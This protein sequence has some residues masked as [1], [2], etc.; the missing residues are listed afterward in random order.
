[1]NK[2]HRF[3]ILAMVSLFLLGI[4][5]FDA[6]SESAVLISAGDISLIE[7]KY[8]CE[9][10]VTGFVPDGYRFTVVRYNKDGAVLETVYIDAAEKTQL[11]FEAADISDFCEISLTASD[12]SALCEPA[13][14]LLNRLRAP[15]WKDLADTL[16]LLTKRYSGIIELNGSS[17]EYSSGRLIV[18]CSGELPDIS[19][20]NPE[21]VIMDDDSYYFIQFLS[22]DSAK[23]CSEYLSGFSCVQYS[24]PD[25]DVSI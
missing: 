18:K 2:N 20:F 10:S 5:A 9:L 13:T 25:S 22:S 11:C 15:G 19:D 6:V 3:R 17:L 14:L 24:E 1:M 8:L 21:A 12:G 23:A 16:A 7:G 4:F